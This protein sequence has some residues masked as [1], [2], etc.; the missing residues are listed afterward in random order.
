M[1]RYVSLFHFT[2]LGRGA[3]KK[4]P[5]RAEAFIKSCRQAGI[6]VEALLWTV[7]TYDGLVIIK[8]KN[9]VKALNALAKLGALGN[10]RTE[11]LQAFDA[12]EFAEILRG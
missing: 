9:H 2:R 6:T 3:I 10:V 5:D 8:A 7:G 11:T 12:K 4:S 1:A